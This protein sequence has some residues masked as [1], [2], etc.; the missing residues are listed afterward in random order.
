MPFFNLDR[1]KGIRSR[2][3]YFLLM[4]LTILCYLVVEKSKSK[5]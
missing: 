3:E 5:F 2:D 4:V 1:F